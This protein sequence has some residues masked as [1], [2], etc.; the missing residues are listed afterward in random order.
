MY[1]LLNFQQLTSSKLYVLSSV[2]LFDFIIND[3][4][5]I[6]RCNPDSVS[7]EYKQ[8]YLRSFYTTQKNT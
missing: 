2:I 1:I 7:R 8:M 6:N 3:N 4:Y 5:N